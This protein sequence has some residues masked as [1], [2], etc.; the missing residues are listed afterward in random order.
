MTTRTR[1]EHPA[2][3]HDY[4]RELCKVMIQKRHPLIK[5]G[6]YANW[7]APSLRL[8]IN[9]RD[10][11]GVDIYFAFP[12][13]FAGHALRVEDKRERPEAAKEKTQRLAA[14]N[15]KRIWGDQ[16]AEIGDLI[17]DQLERIQKKS[18]NK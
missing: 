7:H 18:E 4:M 9:L 11:E 17:F 8:Y 5:A 16:V 14:Q 6:T 12:R 13:D 3:I 15:I 1:Y 10:Y 2:I